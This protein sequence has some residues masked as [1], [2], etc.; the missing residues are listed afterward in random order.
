MKDR[1]RSI[2]QITE[3]AWKS[4]WRAE[5]ADRHW[6]ALDYILEGLE[7]DPVCYELL[8]YAGELLN[9]AWE[10]MG[11]CDKESAERAIPYFDRAIAA[12]PEMAEAYIC[13]ALALNDLERPEQAL[14]IL[15]VGGDLY[16]QWPNTDVYPAVRVN[17]GE[18]LYNHR[19]VAL[20]Q[21]RRTDEARQVL[22]EGL[23]RFPESTYL[24]ELTERF[25][26]PELTGGV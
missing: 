3:R 17:I 12:K 22:N 19:V 9:T 18:S 25:L 13:K 7:A 6:T 10:D 16:E 11:L 8:V 1:N 24:T 26:P 2:E 20:L 21:L 15:E 4:A 14:A 23:R 5:Q